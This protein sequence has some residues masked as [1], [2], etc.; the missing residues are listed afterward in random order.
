M[1]EEKKKRCRLAKVILQNSIHQNQTNVFAK[2]IPQ[3]PKSKNVT[4]L[5]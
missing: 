5:A 3:I 1:V 4:K 2:Q